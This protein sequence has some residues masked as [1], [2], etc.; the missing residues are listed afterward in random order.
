M[1]QDHA[2]LLG[3]LYS[4]AASIRIMP[5]KVGSQ[6]WQSD[7]NKRGNSADAHPQEVE[8]ERTRW[9]R[10][11]YPMLMTLFEKDGVPCADARTLT[12]QDYPEPLRTKLVLMQKGQEKLI[13]K[14]PPSVHTVKGMT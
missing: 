14:L 13:A 9:S 7:I 4:N 2:P 8:R 10:F 5:D 3:S 11:R 12:P 1:D 6:H